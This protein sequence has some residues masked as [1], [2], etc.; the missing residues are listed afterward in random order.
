MKTNL[1]HCFFNRLPIIC[2]LIF[3]SL[4]VQSQSYTVPNAA[5]QPQWVMPLWFTNGDGQKDT[6]Y[7]CYDVESVSNGYSDD[8]DSLL[9]E[10]II[11]VDA[12][13]F[14]GTFEAVGINDSLLNKVDVNYDLSFAEITI[15]FENVIF[16]LRLN[17]DRNVFYSD[18]LQYPS[19][20]P[21][22]NAEGR[23]WFDFPTEVDACSF[24]APIIMTDSV[25][26]PTFTCYLSDS[27]IFTGSGISPFQFSVHAWK[28]T[29][30]GLDQN[31]SSKAFGVIP[32]PVSN[33]ALINIPTIS[34]SIV[35]N[36]YNALGIQICNQNL[37][38]IQTNL[39]V[40]NVPNG[41]YYYTISKDQKISICNKLIVQH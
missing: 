14:N 39:N 16:P 34:G 9:G 26:N 2:S 10:K 24:S 15:F 32:N 20:Y 1:K 22:P 21:A 33:E 6:L 5:I 4:N 31:Y 30:V 41:I 28:G 3:L 7:F 40:S 17:W 13:K 23:L 19:L 37:C 36:L 8:I 18:S 35:F 27:I 12:Q 38:E 11:K 25:L 29:Y